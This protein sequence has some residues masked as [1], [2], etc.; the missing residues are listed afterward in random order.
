MHV[1]GL[2]APLDFGTNFQPYLGYWACQKGMQYTLISIIGEYVGEK[3]RT[4]GLLG[5]GA[6]TR[7]IVWIE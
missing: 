2:L 1:S 5:D 7:L 6:E 3:L 4:H